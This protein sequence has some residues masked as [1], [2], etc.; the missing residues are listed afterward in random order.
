MTVKPSSV[1]SCFKTRERVAPQGNPSESSS[2]RK[3]ELDRFSN[4]L[5]DVIDQSLS[6]WPMKEA[7]KTS[8]LSSKWR[9]KTATLPHLVFDNQCF[10]T[11]P[12]A[13]FEHL[14]KLVHQGPIATGP[15]VRWSLHQSRSAIKEFV[16]EVWRWNPDEMPSS[17]F[18][19]QDLV[20]SRIYNCFAQTSFHIQRIQDGLTHL[21]INAPNLQFF[22]FVGYF[23]DL[24]LENMLKLVQVCI[25]LDS[26][27]IRLVPFSFS[28]LVKFFV[29]LPLIRRITTQNDFR[30]TSIYLALGLSSEAARILVYFSLSAQVLSAQCLLRS[31]PALQEL[32]IMVCVDETD[33]QE[34][35]SWLDDYQ[36][37]QFSQLRLVKPT[38]LI[39]AFKFKCAREDDS[40]LFLARAC[41]SLYA[42]IIYL[43]P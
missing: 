43:G 26:D 15:V 28:P 27:S 23:G 35:I 21:K 32:E 12:I 17:L 18:S 38:F 3:T 42:E 6:R 24:N 29:H 40:S 1:N 4:L 8:V 31:S 36:N 34:G 16:L 9:Y 37:Y 20:I 11:K 10:P 39:S 7:W 25:D 19:C 41:L 33:V 30:G 5:S 2:K 22:Y 14:I 13:T